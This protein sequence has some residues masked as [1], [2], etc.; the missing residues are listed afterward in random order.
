MKKGLISVIIPV[1]N[2]EVFLRQCLNSVLNQSYNNFELILVDDGSTDRSGKICDEYAAKDNRIKTFHISNH[3]VGHARNVGL[4]NAQGEYISFVDSDDWLERDFFRT[5]MN[6]SNDY[7][8]VYISYSFLFLDGTIISYKLPQKQAKSKIELNKI[9]LYLKRNDACH[10]F[11][12]Y[13]WNKIFRADI[14]KNY[15]LRFIENLTLC[16]DEAFTDNYC[17]YINSIALVPDPLYNYRANLLGL[18]GRNRTNKEYMLLFESIDNN[19][20]AYSYQPLI[21][22]ERKRQCELLDRALSRDGSLQDLKSELE[23]LVK[24]SRKYNVRIRWSRRFAW[25]MGP[26][27]G[28]I[29]KLYQ[30]LF[31]L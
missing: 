1:Y 22:F 23:L 6:W 19:I 26:F 10:P 5:L 21:D 4:D 31:H 13:T 11:F 2:V 3:G 8:L 28:I 18:T 20:D 9:I 16:E 14:I 17:R 7:E 15:D 27:A 25:T 29:L 24:Y 30:K 12:G